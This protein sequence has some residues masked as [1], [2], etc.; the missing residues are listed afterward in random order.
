MNSKKAGRIYQ[1]IG[2][3]FIAIL[4]LAACQP[5]GAAPT[6]P[7]DPYSALP[8]TAAA[9]PTV[10]AAKVTVSDQSVDGG[11]LTI[12]EVDSPATGW[13]VIHAQASGKPGPVLGYSPVKAGVNT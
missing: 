2:L 1:T 11:K 12:A 8:P 4:V 13:L 9:T 6:A 7:V 10:V 3:A 5:T